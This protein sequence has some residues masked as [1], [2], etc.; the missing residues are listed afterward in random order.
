MRLLIVNLGLFRW[1]DVAESAGVP[2][3]IVES[4]AVCFLDA[5]DCYYLLVTFKSVGMRVLIVNL[6]LFAPIDVAESAGI[7]ISLA[8]SASMC[9]LI[10]MNC[11]CLLL[12]TCVYIWAKLSFCVRVI[13]GI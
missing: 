10:A 2:I 7:Q 4:I 1:I 5:M 9:F 13:L 3:D 8:E 6:V 11:Y 12:T